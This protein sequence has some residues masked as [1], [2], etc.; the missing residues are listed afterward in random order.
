[1]C[2]KIRCDR[3]C[4]NFFGLHGQLNGPEI[5]LLLGRPRCCFDS[6]TT[7]SH[8]IGARTEEW[9]KQGSEFPAGPTHVPVSV[10]VAHAS[11]LSSKGNGD[12]D[13]LGNE[14]IHSISAS[15]IHV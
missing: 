14:Y 10:C 1:M 13:V 11:C 5:G 6:S 7:T 2:R 12:A 8:R 3:Y 4:A 9:L 15:S